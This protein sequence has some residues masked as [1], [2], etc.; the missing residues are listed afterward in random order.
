VPKQRSTRRNA[1]D[2]EA[3]KVD[4]SHVKGLLSSSSTTGVE[5]DM[6]EFSHTNDLI[7]NA[8][9]WMTRVKD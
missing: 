9:E 5:M 4:L 1:P 8:E 6:K 3:E 7:E 2:V